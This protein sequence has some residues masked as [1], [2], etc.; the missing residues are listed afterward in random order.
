MKST[1]VILTI[2]VCLICSYGMYGQFGVAVGGGLNKSILHTKNVGIL[3][4]DYPAG[5][6][7]FIALRPEIKIDKLFGLSSDIQFSQK[8]FSDNN[9][10][11]NRLDYS[12]NSLDI[13]T[14]LEIKIMTQVGLIG[15]TV[16]SFNIS[17]DVT[18]KGQMPTPPIYPNEKLNFG[19]VAGI[20]IHLPAKVS[21]PLQYIRNSSEFVNVS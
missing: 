2:I 6:G 17:N 9:I 12:I 3:N 13:T 5:F 15:G 16:T 14:L 4:K 11:N 20:R 8:K 19:Y 7:Y 1:P 10:L 18:S 21:W